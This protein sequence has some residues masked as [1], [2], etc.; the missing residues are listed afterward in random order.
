[1]VERENSGLPACMKNNGVCVAYEFLSPPNLY[2]EEKEGKERGEGQ[3]KD[4]GEEGGGTR[5][6]EKEGRGEGGENLEN[7]KS[8]SGEVKKTGCL[9]SVGGGEEYSLIKKG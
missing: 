1:M 6:G 5:T 8:S 2:R 3:E 7:Q 9:A 4:E